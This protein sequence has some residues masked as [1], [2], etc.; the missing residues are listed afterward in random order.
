MKKSSCQTKILTDSNLYGKNLPFIVIT[1]L[2][3]LGSSFF[4]MSI[5]KSMALMMPSPNISW[6]IAF[7]VVP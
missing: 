5:S 7:I 6:M 2:S 4:W 1:T 3:P